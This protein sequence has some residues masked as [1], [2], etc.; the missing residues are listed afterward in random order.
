[1]KNN[2]DYIRIR[3]TLLVSLI[4]I[5]IFLLSVSI[6][7]KI[8]RTKKTISYNQNN[9][10]IK[11]STVKYRDNGI[12]DLTINPV[13][14]VYLTKEK[15]IEKMNLEEYIKGVVAAEMPAGF[16]IEALKAQAIAART[17]ALDHMESAG[18]KK[19]P[20]AKG[21]DID[22][23]VNCQ[24]YISK[25]SIMKAWSK[26]KR[27]EY[28]NKICKAV[29]STKGMILTYNDK[30]V[31]QPFYFSTSSGRTEDASEVFSVNVPYLRSVSSPGEENAPK[32]HTIFKFSYNS[33]VKTINKYYSNSNIYK[34]NLPQN[35]KI[36]E[37]SEGGS[38]KK[39][40]IGNIIVTGFK[41]RNMFGL[42]SAN[43]NINFSSNYMTITCKGYGHGVGMSQWGANAMAKSGKNYIEI[44]KHYYKG[45]DITH[46]KYLTE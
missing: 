1:M 10:E 14:E 38:V 19:Y 9:F 17:Y 16:E 31:R 36:L 40:R 39:I 45:V 18:G 24:A 20:R 44:L 43:F 4:V 30:I 15:R 29:D 12:G 37:R 25:A 35:V 21:A 13:I 6:L 3:N 11:E 34:Y 42:T 26:N 23:T 32:Y 41:F 7:S 22:D 33:V 27:E 2:Y 46:I 28:W 8:Y 5:L